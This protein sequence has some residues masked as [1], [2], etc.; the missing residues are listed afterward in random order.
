MSLWVFV[1]FV[2][3]FF[4]PVTEWK[5]REEL[6]SWVNVGVS[7]TVGH[8]GLNVLAVGSDASAVIGRSMGVN[9]ET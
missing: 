6:G 8:R 7:S 4:G 2:L 5:T 3:P 1:F 9:S